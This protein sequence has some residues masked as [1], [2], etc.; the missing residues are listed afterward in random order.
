[1]PIKNS[2]CLC[3]CSCSSLIP[4]PLLAAQI[5]FPQTAYTLRLAPLLDFHRAHFAIESHACQLPAIQPRRKVLEY[6]RVVE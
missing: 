2:R 6:N 4:F 3:S 5:Y 1:M